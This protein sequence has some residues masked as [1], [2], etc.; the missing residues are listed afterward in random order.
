[1]FKD[2]IKVKGFFSIERYDVYTN[3]LLDVFDKQNLVMNVGRSKLA[4]ISAGFSNNIINKIVLGTKGH[5]D[6]NL[7]QPKTEADGFNSSLTKL[8]SQADSSFTYTINFTPT[9]N[10]GQA[11]V[12]EDT[13]GA[14][15][16]VTV[17]QTDDIINYEIDLNENA[18][19]NIN[20]SIV[21]Y[22]E[23]GMFMGS[24]LF[25]M[26]TF[27]VRSKDSGI[28]FKIKWSFVF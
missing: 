10:G 21:G 2:T 26:R 15:S 17:T 20:G 5:V 8:F 11:L 3:T 19:N 25:A 6:G 12:S 14:G 7:L 16:I 22:T 28:R 18:G 27:P 4:S 24:T 9:T 23:A 13:K 1:M